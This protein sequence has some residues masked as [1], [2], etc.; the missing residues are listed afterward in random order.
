MN[1]RIHNLERTGKGLQV[2]LFLRVYRKIAMSLS[3]F[4]L[5]PP[6]IAEE[7]IFLK[8]GLNELTIQ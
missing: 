5:R 4:E 1:L 8:H 3:T 7:N 6:T 2:Y